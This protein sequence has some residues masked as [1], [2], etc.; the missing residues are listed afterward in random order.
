MIIVFVIFNFD[1]LVKSPRR[2]NFQISHYIISIGY[3]I[4]I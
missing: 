3:E 2:A 1:G 4:E